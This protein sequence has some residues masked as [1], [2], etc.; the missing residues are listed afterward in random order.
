VPTYGSI[1]AWSNNVSIFSLPNADPDHHLTDEHAVGWVSRTLAERFRGFTLPIPVG[2]GCCLMVSTDVVR[3]IGLFDPVFGR[4]YCEEVDLCLRAAA[5][6][7]PNV[8]ALGTFVYH[9]G[10]ASTKELGLLAP[11]HSTVVGHERIIDHRHPGYRQTVQQFLA[12][13]QLAVRRTEAISHVVCRGASEW[14][15]SL[16]V[17]A[18]DTGWPE[19]ERAA[20]RWSSEQPDV[21]DARFRGFGQRI[22]ID[23]RDVV[24]D[25][26]HRI[27]RPPEGVRAVE[28]TPG[29][30][31]VAGR[32]AAL[33]TPVDRVLAYPE[34]TL[35]LV[36]R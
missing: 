15:W 6:G 14:G 2:V 10:N 5:A 35:P 13:D 3:E 36:T 19:D 23:G 33:G 24:G 11:G 7:H 1:T 25:L 8:L 27:G 17:S 18:L 22:P 4:G 21:V 34:R 20:F 29:A 16:A 31:E 28:G 9:E 32:A 26:T 12:D 30:V